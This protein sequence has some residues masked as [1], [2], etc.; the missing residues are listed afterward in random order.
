MALL[1]LPAL[2]ASTAVP[3]AAGLAPVVTGTAVPLAPLPDPNA[4]PPGTTAETGFWGVMDKLMGVTTYRDSSGNWVPTR[5]Q[6]NGI[7]KDNAVITGAVDKTLG[8][9]SKWVQDNWPLLIMFALV[10]L[11]AFYGLS[12]ATRKN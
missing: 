7:K 3:G 2:G 4:Q 6:A 8:S 1:T 9:P 12:A 10:L 11:L 5:D